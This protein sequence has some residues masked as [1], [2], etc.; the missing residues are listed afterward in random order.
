MHSKPLVGVERLELQQ[1]PAQFYGADFPAFFLHMV[2]FKFWGVYDNFSGGEKLDNTKSKGA[3]RLGRSLCYLEKLFFDFGY[4]E[5]GDMFDA[6][7]DYG[8]ACGTDMSSATEVGTN[9]GDVNGIR[10]TC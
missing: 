5:V 3:I 1:S 10:G 6:V 2:L 4:Y 8:A 9:R 7:G